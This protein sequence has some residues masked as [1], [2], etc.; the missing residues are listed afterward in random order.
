MRVNKNSLYLYGWRI[1][2]YSQGN[3]FATKLVELELVF[4]DEM[5]ENM[6][7][8]KRIGFFTQL[9]EKIEIHKKAQTKIVNLR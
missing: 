5:Y 2:I 3:L 7:E 6:N 9:I 1:F 4:F 8:S